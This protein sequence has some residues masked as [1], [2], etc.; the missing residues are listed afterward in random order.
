MI[1]Y[2]FLGSIYVYWCICVETKINSYRI[3]D[4]YYERMKINNENEDEDDDDMIDFFCKF[5][6]DSYSDNV[7][8]VFL[9]KNYLK[10]YFDLIIL[11]FNFIAAV[12]IPLSGDHSSD[13]IRIF[14]G[15]SAFFNPF[16]KPDSRNDLRT[17]FTRRSSSFASER[18]TRYD[19]AKR[20][21]RFALGMIKATKEKYSPLASL[22]RSF[23]RSIILNVPSGCNSAISPVRNQ[24][25]PRRELA[26]EP[27]ISS[28]RGYGLSVTR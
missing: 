16:F 14:V 27:I 24:V 2:V 13:R 5:H 25:I 20:P 9:F 23:L 26:F 19:L 22:T 3:F 17:I 6:N 15:I 8:V 11:R 1:V 28:P 7:V 10:L 18:G 12:N 4:R 21:N